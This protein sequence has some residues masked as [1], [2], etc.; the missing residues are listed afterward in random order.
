MNV[1]R[2]VKLLDQLR[3][4][5]LLEDNQ[6]AE[7]ARLPEAQGPGPGGLERILVQRGL[8][9]R[10]QVNQVAQG[11]G[12]E[13]RLGSFLLL[14]PLGKGG[15]G[16]VFKARHRGLGR[17]VALKLIRKEKLSNATSVKRF[18]QEVQAA[19]ALN[20]PNIVL[21]YDAG[22]A[23]NTHYFS[24]EFVEGKDLARLV[25]QNGPLPVSLACEF[26]RQAALGLQ[27]AHEKGLI[28]R[29][30]KPHN[31]LV[32][33]AAGTP[34]VKLLDMGLARLQGQGETG[35]TQSGQVLGTPEYLAPEQAIDSHKAD[36]RSDIYS[37][38]CTLYFLLTGRAP[39]TG[40]TLTE[41]LLKHQM[42][43][44][45]TLTT[46]PR[47]LAAVVR[48]MMAKQPDDRYQTPAEVVEAL[49]AFA[50][51]EDITAGAVGPAAADDSNDPW[52]DLAGDDLTWRA[53]TQV[54]QAERAPRSRREQER[55]PSRAVLFGLVG[56]G[57]TVPLLGVLV[58]AA[59]LLAASP[60]KADPGNLKGTTRTTRS[61]SR[62]TRP[63]NETDRP[64]VDN[65]V[66]RVPFTGAS[67]SRSA[68]RPGVLS[69]EFGGTALSSAW[70]SSATGAGQANL[71]VS[72]GILSLLATEV[73]SVH[74]FA[75]VP[76]EGTVGFGGTA[77]Q[78]FGLSCTANGVTNWALFS[79]AATSDTLF[80][81]VNTNGT[82]E[83]VRLGALPSGF[84]D[85]LIKP[86]SGG[87]QF[88][89]DGALKTTITVTMPATT[90]FKILMSD[91]TGT[92]GAPL[93]VDRVRIGPDTAGRSS[94]RRGSM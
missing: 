90:P 87:F 28:H 9:N 70:T 65:L 67:K 8:L 5:E 14:E 57:A 62:T 30:I 78:H 3:E 31:L 91:H 85:Y 38:G 75:N 47:A 74:T 37:L 23:G 86:L 6:L 84:H 45:P 43:E 22:L 52:R 46:V 55:K 35:L 58:L 48:K 42:E 11:K 72:E 68:A 12:R 26:T 16:M 32:T 79:T 53:A 54:V 60:K 88:W 93:R 2:Q 82:E 66:V 25:K 19:A 83:N 1:D 33:M 18:Y 4:A 81:R 80:A 10:F 49:A 17:V 21:A 94:P 63:G 44:A 64:S 40:E 71:T 24:M 41:V 7:L 39:F 69:D 15:M 27:H 92:T 56:A 61:P 76:L 36:A 13:L 20:H 29:D 73:D 34:L 77:W 59:T 51:G 50:R 89:I